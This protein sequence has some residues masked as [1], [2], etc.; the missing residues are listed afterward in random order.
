MAT[1][2]LL[3]ADVPD[4]GAEGDIVKV[5]DGFARN[6]LLP[7]KIAAP[8]TK[9]AHARL[10]IIREKRK[11]ALVEQL[12]GARELASK[13]TGC[14]CTITVSTGQDDKLYGSVSTADIARALGKQG[15][16]IDRVSGDCVYALVVGCCQQGR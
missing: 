5:A 10:G 4:L 7:K 9:A 14:S 2:V 12:A 15:I 3:M 16:E 1:E 8:V 6:Y 11:E 13:L